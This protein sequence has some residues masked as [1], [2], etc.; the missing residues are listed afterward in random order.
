[1][2]KAKK[3][4][5]ILLVY[6]NLP[7]MLVHLLYLSKCSTILYKPMKKRIRGVA[8]PGIFIVVF[9]IAHNP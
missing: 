7:L 9:L 8:Q 3:D 6:P 2:I 5:K 4:F 1:M